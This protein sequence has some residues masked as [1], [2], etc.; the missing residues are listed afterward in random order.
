MHEVSAAWLMTLLT[1]KP[2]LVALVQATSA[3]SVCILAIPA[4]ALA[5]ILDRR[6][7]LI[8]LQSWMMI[9]AAILAIVTFMGKMSPPLLLALTFCLGAGTALNAPTWQATV[10]DLVPTKDL[11]PAITLNSMGVNFSRTIGPF[12]A[13]FII[14]LSGPAMVFALNAVSF[15][16]III[17]LSRWKREQPV[18]TLP[19]ERFFG[20]MRSGLRYVRSSPILIKVFIKSSA[21]FFF[22]SA[23]WAMLPL[24]ARVMLH[25][26]SIGYGIL[27]G[28]LG[29][30]AVSGALC[31]HTIRRLLN[32]D[33]L[34]F[35]GGLLFAVSLL[36]I[37]IFQQFYAT[38]GAMY[39]IGFAWISVLSTLNSVVQQSVP[40]WVRAR[41]VSVYLMAFFGG[42]AIGGVIWGI[43]ITHIS[44]SSTLIIASM[45]LI[46]ANILVYHLTLEKGI[47]YDHT[48]S[49]D[50]PAPDVEK[51]LDHDEGPVMVSVEYEVEPDNVAHFLK[52]IQEL[53]VTRLR[54]GAFFWSVFNDIENTTR[55]IECFMVES[56][57]EHLRFHERVSISDRKI[58][59]KVN[60]Y[61]AG[62]GRPHTT[63]FVACELPRKGIRKKRHKPIF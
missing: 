36:I 7:Y 28:M 54:E 37:A 57:L 35:V 3:F 60:A 44:M 59:D 53:R 13:G 4:G 56:W 45:G 17:T 15:L 41:A 24:I 46:I 58:Q 29:L 9:I 31:N 16:G 62:P 19:T 47:L 39:I 61:H 55:Y 6:R 38:C 8:V 20:A 10:P 23:A 40:P 49:M 52:V 1:T 25:Q 27:L 22:I 63:H 26:G 11:V 21:N 33:Q 42:M 51:K 34:I 48:P 14:A 2:F 5:D 50:L 30:G 32:L 43:C 12:L 18:S